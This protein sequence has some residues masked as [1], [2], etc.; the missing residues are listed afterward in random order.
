M[1]NSIRY[2]RK[3]LTFPDLSDLEKHVEVT[4]EIRKKFLDQILTWAKDPETGP[5]KY[6]PVTWVEIALGEGYDSDRWV[7]DWDDE[8]L[9]KEFLATL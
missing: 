9:L 8:I 7:E 4:S 6:D 3:L 1:S 5:S 2:N